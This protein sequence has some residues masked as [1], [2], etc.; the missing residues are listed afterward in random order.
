MHILFQIGGNCKD[1]FLEL[2]K[3]IFLGTWP[4]C[5]FWKHN[6]TKASLLNRE[7]PA[8]RSQRPIRNWSMDAANRLSNNMTRGP[9]VL[10]RVLLSF[11]SQSQHRQDMDAALPA[12][13]AATAAQMWNSAYTQDLHHFFTKMVTSIST[14]HNSWSHVCMV[15]AN[16]LGYPAQEIWKEETGQDF[17][18]TS[19]TKTQHH[20]SRRTVLLTSVIVCGYFSS[21]RHRWLQLSRTTVIIEHETSRNSH[22]PHPTFLHTDGICSVTLPAHSHWASHGFFLLP[23]QSHTTQPL[24]TCFTLKN[25]VAG[26]LALE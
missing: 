20:Q 7:I 22:S 15:A 5:F 18:I 14:K 3:L 4:L 17:P 10:Y 16:L 19:E 11:I 21:L 13:V 2:K 6:K 9:P 23:I 25:H 24:P 8:D 12:T 26:H 1:K